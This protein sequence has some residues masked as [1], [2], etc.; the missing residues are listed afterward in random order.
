MLYKRGGPFNVLRP[1][2]HGPKLMGEDLVERQRAPTNEPIVD[3]LVRTYRSAAADR[4]L[5]PLYCR[6]GLVPQPNRQHQKTRDQQRAREQH[7]SRCETT[8]T[9]L[10]IAT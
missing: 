4:A 9:V 2:F 8:R 5:A 7:G 10:Q 3:R 6:G 1:L